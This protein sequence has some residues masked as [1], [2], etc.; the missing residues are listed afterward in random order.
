MSEYEDKENVVKVGFYD[1][2]G[3][4]ETLLAAPHWIFH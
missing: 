3:E 4:V 1:K 2:D